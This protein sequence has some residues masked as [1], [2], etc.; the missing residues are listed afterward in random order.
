MVTNDEAEV[1]DLVL[2]TGASRGIGA[3]TARAL[4]REHGMNVLLVSRD[5]KAMAEVVSSCTDPNK[6]EIMSIDLSLPEA[7]EDIRRKVGE[8]RLRAVINNAGLFRSMQLGHWTLDDLEE[9]FRVN[10]HVPFLLVQALADRL[11]G[12]PPGHVVNIGSMGGVQGSVKFPGLSGYSA[13]KAALAGY[14]ECL[15]EELRHRGIACNCLALGSVDTEMLR[16]AFPDHRAELTVAEMGSYV[17]R[18]ALEG[19]KFF[20]AKVLPV[21]TGTP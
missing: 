20:N 19:H 9:I 17:A 8:R 2:I 16:A 13:S 14:T 18:F 4:V 12:E 6:A 11:V 1:A 7:V 10:A 21:S 15:A 5:A 3:A